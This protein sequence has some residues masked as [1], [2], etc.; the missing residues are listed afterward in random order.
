MKIK[1][2]GNNIPGFTYGC[3]YCASTLH[4]EWFDIKLHND[5]IAT[6]TCPVCNGEHLQE[7]VVLGENKAN[8]IID[9]YYALTPD[10]V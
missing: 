3:K 7:L 2:R 10:D 9:A 4:V 8:S 5:K 1:E 6:F